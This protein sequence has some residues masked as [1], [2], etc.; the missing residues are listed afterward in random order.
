MDLYYMNMYI[1]LHA[2]ESILQADIHVAV[3]NWDKIP[4]LSD[5]LAIPVVCRL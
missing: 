4:T 2:L 1:I 5:R 3:A